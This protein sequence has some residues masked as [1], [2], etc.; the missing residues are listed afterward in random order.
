MLDGT[1]RWVLTKADA[2]RFGAPPD[3]APVGGVSTMTLRNRKWQIGEGSDAPAGTFAVRGDRIAFNWENALL[4]FT[5]ARDRDG[6][7]HLTP[8]P[9]VERGDRF[10]WSSEPW[11]RIGPPV[12][13]IP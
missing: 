3:E 5:F 2:I 8:A 7:L 1:Y 4:I 11:R 6:T 13:D 10:V 12:R 9:S